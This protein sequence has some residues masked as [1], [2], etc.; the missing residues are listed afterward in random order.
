MRGQSYGRKRVLLRPQTQILGRL[1]PDDEHSSERGDMV[2]AVGALC[3]EV[4]ATPMGSGV[5]HP[6]WLY[7]LG[8]LLVPQCSGQTRHRKILAE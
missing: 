6:F 8:S 5:I 2:A 3:V 7:A 4:G 1:I